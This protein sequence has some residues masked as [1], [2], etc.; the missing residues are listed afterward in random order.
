[1]VSALSVPRL[2]TTSPLA[3]KKSPAEFFVEFRGSG[4]IEQ[5]IPRR[6]HSELKF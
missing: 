1:V 4:V 6:L 5:D 2:Y 3:A